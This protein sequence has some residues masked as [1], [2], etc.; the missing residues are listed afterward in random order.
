MVEQDSTNA[1]QSSAG[2]SVQGETKGYLVKCINKHP[3]EK[4]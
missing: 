4:R 3:I 2:V 1:K